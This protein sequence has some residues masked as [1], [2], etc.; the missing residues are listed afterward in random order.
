MVERLSDAEFQSAEGVDDWR[1]VYGGARACFRTRDFVTGG[2]LVAAIVEHAE[3]LGHHPDVDLRYASVTVHTQTHDVHGLTELD[4]DL[5]R[6]ISA[7]AAALGV[8]ADPTA[9]Q[10]VELA[11]DAV[12]PAEVARFWQAALGYKVVRDHDLVDRRRIGPAVG[13]FEIAEH[14]PPHNRLHVD[15]SVPHDVA[16]SRVA[17]VL[18]AGGRLLG[19]KYAPA[20]WSLIDPEGNVADIATWQGRD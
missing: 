4:V 12:Q 17:A 19:D 2:R 13:V 1:V 14:R 20:W 15:I 5:A 11:I 18:D 10:V 7:S 3:A 6:R 9:V 16:E 8:A